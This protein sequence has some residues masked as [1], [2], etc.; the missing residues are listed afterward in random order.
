M[1]L[2]T[3]EA[4]IRNIDLDI[5]EVDVTE[6]GA[7]CPTTGERERTTVFVRELTAREKNQWA[8]SFAKQKG[9]SVKFD[10]KNMWL[11]LV[12]ATCCDAEGNRIFQEADVDY[13]ANL[14]TRIFD[15]ILTAAQTLNGFTS[16]EEEED[17]IKN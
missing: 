14:P 10:L 5:V 13:L 12:I 16:E 17:T 6:L 8:E 9:K 3:R 15:R 2:L 11:M 4:I 7:I 1:P